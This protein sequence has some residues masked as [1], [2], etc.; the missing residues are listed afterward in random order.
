MQDR[1][2]RAARRDLFLILSRPRRHAPPCGV[3]ELGDERRDDAPAH[4]VAVGAYVQAI[5][6]GLHPPPSPTFGPPPPATGSPCRPRSPR[7]P[8]P[9]PPAIAPAP[10]EWTSPTSWPTPFTTPFFQRDCTRLPW[11][12]RHA[13]SDV[14][15]GHN[16]MQSLLPALQIAPVIPRV[17]IHLVLYRPIGPDHES[18]ASAHQA[19]TAA[20]RAA[21]R[22]PLLDMRA[23]SRPHAQV[24]V[25]EV[26][27]GRVA[28]GAAWVGVGRPAL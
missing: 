16:C 6:G 25:V 26:A 11:A 15:R 1:G 14:A 8:T 9:S 24:D 12:G 21:R 22:N 13:S 2:R 18:W 20:P 3:R 19:S 4:V 10:R 27:E 5:L 28:R 23:R 7:P 17:N